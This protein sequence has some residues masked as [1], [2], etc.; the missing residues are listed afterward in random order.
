ME[1][2]LTKQGS[3]YRRY[4]IFTVDNT[5]LYLVTKGDPMYKVYSQTVTGEIVHMQTVK[6]KT[7]ED[8]LK[9]ALGMET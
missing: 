3:G 1:I 7:Y 8:A 2:K 6:S 9:K 4:K 5:G